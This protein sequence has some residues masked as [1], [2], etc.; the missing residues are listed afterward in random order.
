M[1]KA[2][3][4]TA[5]FTAFLNIP[6]APA[7]DTKAD[8]WDVDRC[9]AYAVKH[10]HTVRQRELSLDN[11]KADRL[12]AA[13]SFLPGISIGSGMQYNFGRSVD[14]ETNTYKDVSTF[15]NNYS[16]YA[17]MPLFNGGGLVAQLR[18]AHIGTLLG[19]A[20]LEQARDDAALRTFEAFIQVVYY[21]GC[22][23]IARRKL[24]E[25]NSLLTKTKLMEELGLKGKADV[26][27]VEAQ[28]ATDMYTLTR[29]E[30]LASTAMLTLKQ[31]MNFPEDSILELT[32][33]NMDIAHRT[34]ENRQ[35]VVAMALVTNPGIRYSELNVKYAGLSRRTAWAG[36]LPS[37]SVSG[38]VSTSYYKTRHVDG[39]P[40]FSRQ[41]H[42]NKGTY[43]GFSLSVPIFNR[44]SGIT[45]IRKAR[46]NFRIAQENCE[47][48]K[49]N[50][51]K[52]VTQAVND[53]DGYWRETVQM[54]QKVKS[55][56]IVYRITRRKYEEGMMTSLDVQNTASTLM[57]SRAKLLQSRLT[58]M[59][60]CRLVDYYKGNSIVRYH[61]ADNKE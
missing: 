60:K 17:S 54:E 30:N 36:V 29:Q 28:K 25:T 7:Q 43:F 35:E 13:G 56:S 9:M 12:R 15:S 34:T 6:K 57:E 42:D 55:D 40:S 38:G 4:L 45:S 5:V 3:F 32:V 48:E 21:N 46:N 18:Q 27:S 31:Q 52:V 22:V 33:G 49:E 39:Y 14:P 16:L 37:L 19:R 50:L 61:P 8:V 2:V 44:F 20:A 58:Y 1:M 53:C 59:L 51:R 23:D 41:F 24:A 26:A 11:N 10:N 47:E